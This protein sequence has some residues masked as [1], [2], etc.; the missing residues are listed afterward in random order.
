MK[1]K[2]EEPKSPT[3][4]CGRVDLYEEM[5]KMEKETEKKESESENP[6]ESDN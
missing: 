3:C 2:K 5:K 6:D 4:A 1:G